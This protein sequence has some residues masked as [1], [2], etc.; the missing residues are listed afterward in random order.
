M[1]NLPEMY[2][3]Q[4]L[5]TD[6][7]P[8]LNKQCPVKRVVIS[9]SGKINLNP[10]NQKFVYFSRT[11]KHHCYYI[12]N[13]I[14][15]MISA[16]ISKLK[17]DTYFSKAKLPSDFRAFT[18]HDNLNIRGIKEVKDIFENYLPP[19][20]LELVKLEYMEC[21]REL[22][23]ICSTLNSK[24]TFGTN[25]PE[26]PDKSRYGGAYGMNTQWLDL[27]QVC[28][29][30]TDTT[31]ISIDKFLGYLLECSKDIKIKGQRL[32]EVMDTNQILFMLLNGLKY[33]HHMN[34]DFNDKDAVNKMSNALRLI[35]DKKLYSP[36]LQLDKR[37]F[38]EQRRKFK[39]EY[40]SVR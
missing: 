27:L 20:E 26:V 34:P 35:E 38:S 11:K 31:S 9:N 7:N 28:T 18:Y 6:N 37:F 5:C 22:F 16:E 14:L 24:K 30:S 36:T 19:K 21:F 13:K 32:S 8:Y 17:K 1:N 2:R 4:S 12:Y 29:K 15:K 39:E 25:Y 33:T 40:H 23:E 3:V 10:D